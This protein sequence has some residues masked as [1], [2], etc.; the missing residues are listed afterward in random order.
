MKILILA[1]HHTAHPHLPHVANEAAAASNEHPGSK[2]LAGQVGER[3]VANAA[4]PGGFDMFW[5]A[6]H[7]VDSD[8]LL[9]DSILPAD[10][11]ITYIKAS[12]A[13]T[14]FL[15]TC[16]SVAI[17]QR[18][19][20][21]TDAHAIT[22]VSDLPDEHAMAT[23]ILFARQLATLGDPRQAYERSKPA[24]NKIYLF[25][26]NAHPKPTFKP[27][28]P[29]KR[30]GQ[31]GNKNAMSHGVYAK[32]LHT[33]PDLRDLMSAGLEHEIGMLRAR[34]RR[35]LELGTD[36]EDLDATT[37]HLDAL[38]NA[39]VRLATLLRTQRLLTPAQSNDVAKVIG[40]ALSAVVKEM[41]L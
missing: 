23:G 36:L 6:T 37:A 31:P 11:L 10:N 17:A 22:T 20:D 29:R 14:V 7:V 19:V 3:D 21:E 1:P 27:R 2:L 34:I 32:S 15:N 16:S 26:Q 5:L 8:V 39:S 35:V 4:G 24:R 38:G 25:L 41:Q 30:G 9:S 28:T 12:G 33:E 40:D 18:I 13:A